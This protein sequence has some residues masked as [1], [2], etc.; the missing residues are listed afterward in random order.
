M[1]LTFRKTLVLAI[2]AS[3]FLIAHALVIAHWLDGVGAIKAAGYLR[4]EFLTGTAI[5]VI[6]AMLVLITNAGVRRGRVQR[7]CP[8]CDHPHGHGAYCSQ[9]GSRVS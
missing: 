1:T 3:V 9:C 5:T 4:E 2:I 8:V 6:L 7:S